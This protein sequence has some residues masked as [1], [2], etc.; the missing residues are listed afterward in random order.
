MTNDGDR[1]RFEQAFSSPNPAHALYGLAKALKVEGMG[2]LAMYQLFAEYRP[3]I[4]Q[5]D[6][7][8][9]AILDTMDVICGGDWAKGRALFEKELTDTDID[10]GESGAKE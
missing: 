7:R 5:A 2:Q 4:D 1:Q 10:I 3:K 9:D 6:P 8:Y